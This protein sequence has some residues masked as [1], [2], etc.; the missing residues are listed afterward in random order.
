VLY[1][2]VTANIE[3]IKKGINDFPFRTFA[4]N[5]SIAAKDFRDSGKTFFESMREIREIVGEETELYI[6]VVG[7][8]AE[9]MVEDAKIARENIT[10]NLCIKIPACTQGFKA[11]QI[12]KSQGFK[13]SCTAVLTVNQA[14]MAAAAGADIIAVYVSRIDQNGGDGIKVI[15]DIIRAYKQL[16]CKVIVCAASVKDPLTVEKVALAGVGYVALDYHVMQQ[17]ATNPL[18]QGILEGFKKDWED[19]YGEG[20]KLLNLV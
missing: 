20:K 12:L 15:E 2:L 1:C 19:A 5:P 11:I 8:T 17:C 9:E 18:T 16:K 13:I 3:M 4:A 7:E 10:G 14:L 6:Q